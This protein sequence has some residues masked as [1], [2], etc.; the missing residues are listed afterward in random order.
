VGERW[1]NHLCA[2]YK[3]MFSHMD[4]YMRFMAN[5]IRHQQPPA[6]VMDVAATLAAEQK[7]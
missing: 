6:A 3:A 2:G 1:H 5:Q 7:S 4:P